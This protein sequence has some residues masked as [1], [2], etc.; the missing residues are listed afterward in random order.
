MVITGAPVGSAASS[1]K[2]SV[3]VD[4]SWTCSR[5][6]AV[7][8]KAIPVNTNGS[9]GIAARRQKRS[10]QHCGQR[11]Q[12]SVQQGGV[13][14][15]TGDVGVGGQ[16]HVGVHHLGTVG[17]LTDTAQRPERAAVAKTMLGQAFIEAVLVDGLGGRHR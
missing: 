7:A 16:S 14:A 2:V 12:G 1:L 8:C 10:Y 3:P 5:V 13:D 9:R 15:I 17:V 4:A 11:V 6:A